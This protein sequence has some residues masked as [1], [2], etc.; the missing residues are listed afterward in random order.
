MEQAN[1][2]SRRRH[3]Q[4]LKRQVL[5]ECAQTG[6]SVARVA[7]AHGLNAN[8]VHKWRRLAARHG[9]G[10]GGGQNRNEIFIPV[11]VAPAGEPAVADIRIE[12]HRGPVAINVTWPMIGAGVCAAWMREILR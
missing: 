11:S 9:G 7:M 2:A 4:E 10:G 5:A 12:L 3:D 6:A 1:A 8:L